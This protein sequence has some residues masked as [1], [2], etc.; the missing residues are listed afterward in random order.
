MQMILFQV[1]HKLNAELK[2][3][4]GQS[5][6]TICLTQSWHQAQGDQRK[7]KLIHFTKESLIV[8]GRTQ[9]IMISIS[10]GSGWSSFAYILIS[11]RVGSDTIACWIKALL[12]MKGMLVK[13]QDPFKYLNWQDLLYSVQYTTRELT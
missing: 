4:Q 12:W 3:K 1:L 7:E 9:F 5:C 8:P 13:A 6:F 10:V 11:S 2:L